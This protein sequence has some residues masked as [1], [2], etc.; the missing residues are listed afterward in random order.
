MCGLA[1]VRHFALQIGHVVFVQLDAPLERL[2]A[3]ENPLVIAFSA[4]AY[5]FLLGKLGSRLVEQLLLVA[6]LVCKYAAAI[7]VTLI[8]RLGIDAREV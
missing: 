1:Q 7:A 8:L 5:G 3:I 4:V 2:K 6:E